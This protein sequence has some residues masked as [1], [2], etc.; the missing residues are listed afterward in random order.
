MKLFL[1]SVA[2]FIVLFLLAG[3]AFA[4]ESLKRSD[5]II[6][7]TIMGNIAL[8][9]LSRQEAREIVKNQILLLRQTS[10]P[11]AA[12]GIVKEVTLQDFGITLNESEIL[13]KI[14]FAGSMANAATLLFSAAGTRV[15]P[16]IRI[17]PT[18][19]LR[20]IFEQFPDIP[21]AKNASFKREG[22]KWTLVEAQTGV[23][24]NLQPLI[25]DLR[26]AIEVFEPPKLFVEFAE[27][28]P[29]VNVAD[30]SPY[31]SSIQEKLNKSIKLI[32]EKKSWTV[33][34]AEHPEWIQF[35]RK[36][37]EVA[38]NE[39]P[40]TMQFDPVA[41]SNFVNSNISHLE[42]APENV[43][44]WRESEGKIQFEGRGNDGRAIERERLLSML[45]V[46]IGALDSEITVPLKVVP[47]KVEVSPE[48]QELGIRELI[49]VGHT[50]FAGSPVNRMHNIRTGI[51][52]FN[53]LIIAP[54]EIFSF[55]KNL[56]EVDASTGY[57]KELVIKPEGTIP[58][59]GGGLCQ[60]STTMFRAAYLAGLPV[61]ERAPHSYIVTYYS[62]VG[63]HG[64]DATVYPPTRDLKFLN[65]T[66]NTIL[67]QSYAEGVDAYFKFYGT[68]DGRGVTMEG[69]Y[70]SN[71][72][73][74]PTEI[75][76]V[77]D[78]TLP[79]G[80][81]KQVEKPHSG[82]DTLWYRNITKNGAT[83]K[84]ELVSRYRAVPAKFLV[85]GTVTAEGENKGLLPEANP[86][87]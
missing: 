2:P 67:V 76:E 25:R 59:F 33:N 56:G 5:R 60:V 29:S 35:D 57:R 84:E 14:P 54:G 65:D 42:Q 28:A 77:P 40:F 48:L 31:Q 38:A 34:F 53:G 23:H 43:R 49:S 19:I 87:E 74:A 3:G 83:V 44:I 78:P 45:N 66:Q 4:M 20:V 75:V 13:E 79:E 17:E 46:S 12:R 47:P 6:P 22:K 32:Y 73:S 37:Y 55:N 70:I 51:S 24:P 80:E 41:F 10:F 16:E 18:E 30:L 21:R 52:K 58:E 72:R 68:S 86:Y 81:R 15:T 63:G 82:F 61:K 64:F 11:L 71:R 50:R 69:P 36:P 39:L 85:G 27:A 62:Q 7:R 9:G 8:S 1:R 26:S